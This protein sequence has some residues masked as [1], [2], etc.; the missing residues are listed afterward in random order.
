MKALLIGATGATGKDLLDLLLKDD[1]FRTVDVFVRRD[2]NIRHEKLKVHII[3][4]DD[5]GEWRHLVNGDVLFSCLGTTIKAAG[6]KKV[7]WKIDYEYQYQFAKIARENGVGTYALIS[8]AYANPRSPFF[9]SK[10]KGK[11]ESA[12]K[13]LAFEKLLIFNPPVLIRK[14]SDRPGETMAVKFISFFNR[15]GLLRSS[16]PLETGI[17]AQ[18]MINASK[19]QKNGI[20]TYE[21]EAIRRVARGN[22]FD[23]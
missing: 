5:P 21:G 7:Q 4:F 11:L 16:R 9:Y 15:M 14:G 18:A 10:M 23:T 1:T 3:N 6:S 13:N 19:K 12:V 22:L 8:A 20:A 17:L 2:I